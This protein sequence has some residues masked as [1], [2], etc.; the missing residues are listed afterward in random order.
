MLIRVVIDSLDD[1]NDEN[2]QVTVAA[3]A[4]MSP[5][6]LGEILRLATQVVKNTIPTLSKGDIREA[7][8]PPDKTK[9][10]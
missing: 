6:Q 10:N 4:S 1:G 7:L 3:D 9:L 2:I 8:L 5:E